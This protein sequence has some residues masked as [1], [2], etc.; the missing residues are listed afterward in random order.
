MSQRQVLSHLVEHQKI[1]DHDIDQALHTSK[2]YPSAHAW[3]AFINQLMLW[4]GSLAVVCGVIFFIAANWQDMGRVV[5]FVFLQSLIVISVIAY[6]RLE[7]KTLFSQVALTSAFILLGALMA[8]FGQTY[9]TGADPWQL[10]FNWA[11]LGLPWVIIA[12]FTPLW[13]LFLVLLNLSLSLYH[14]ALGALLPFG[15]GRENSLF[16]SLWLLNNSSLLVWELRRHV[17]PWLNQ[18]WFGRTLAVATVFNASALA[19]MAIFSFNTS[20]FGGLLWIALMAFAFWFYWKRRPDLFMLALCC[21]ST[22]VVV[23]AWFAHLLENALDVYSLLFLLTIG[24][25]TAATMWL[26]KLMKEFSHA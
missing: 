21:L 1:A 6:L 24:L 23:V 15:I 17:H 11:L 7:K 2:V 20:S 26:K 4:F 18:T 19:M 10:F 14:D 22:I 12:C 16:W 13:L 8:Y 9:Q 25:T 3:P 5:K